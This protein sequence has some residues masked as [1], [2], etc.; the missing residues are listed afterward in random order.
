MRRRAWAA[1]EGA[2]FFSSSSSFDYCSG[3]QALTP[4]GLSPS[5]AQSAAKL[6]VVAWAMGHSPRP[7][8]PTTFDPNHF[9]GRMISGLHLRDTHLH[10]SNRLRGSGTTATASVSRAGGTKVI[11]RPRPVAAWHDTDSKALCKI[12]RKYP[13]MLASSSPSCDAVGR[14]WSRHATSR[15]LPY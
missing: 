10:A 13:E 4:D 6:P 7:A 11:G 15:Y 1:T 8:L 14:A 5:L 12:R 2:F 3:I 9:L